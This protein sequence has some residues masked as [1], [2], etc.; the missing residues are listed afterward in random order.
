MSVFMVF[1]IAIYLYMQL[2]LK[3][4]IM[5]DIIAFHRIIHRCSGSFI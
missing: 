3:P 1:Y 4:G 5:H 2:A